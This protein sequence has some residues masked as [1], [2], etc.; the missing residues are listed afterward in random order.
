[1]EVQIPMERNVYNQGGALRG[2][3]DESEHRGKKKIRE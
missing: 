1:M 2:L 3:D